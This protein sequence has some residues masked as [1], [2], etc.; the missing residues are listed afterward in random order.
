[1]YDSD[2]NAQMCSALKMCYWAEEVWH[3]FAVCNIFCVHK[4]TSVLQNVY[5]WITVL[6]VAQQS[7]SQTSSRSYKGATKLFILVATENGRYLRMNW[8]DKDVLS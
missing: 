2:L 4:I 5:R 7:V 6:A 3:S 1:M 8:Q